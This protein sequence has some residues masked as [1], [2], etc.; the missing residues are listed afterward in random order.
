MPRIVR[1]CLVV[2]ALSVTTAGANG[3]GPL[4]KAVK[5]GDVAAVRALIKSRADVNARFGRRVD[6]AALG[7]SQFQRRDGA[8]AHRR[9]SQGGRRQQLRHHASA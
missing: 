9:R 6:A 7:R 3:D 2:A 1:V 5:A 8:G 4:A